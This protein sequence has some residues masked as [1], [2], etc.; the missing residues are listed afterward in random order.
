MERTME[1]MRDN[2]FTADVK[3][4]DEDQIYEVVGQIPLGNDNWQFSL[5]KKGTPINAATDERFTIVVNK[6][7]KNE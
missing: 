1:Y 7:N 5:I 3:F 2:G 4:T 6:G